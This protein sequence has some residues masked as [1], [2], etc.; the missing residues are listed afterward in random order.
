MAVG[1]LFVV[2]TFASYPLMRMFVQRRTESRVEFYVIVLFLGLLSGIGP[3]GVML[4]E[5]S[6]LFG[7]ERRIAEARQGRSAAK[8]G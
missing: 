7:F 6:R 3:M 5:A 2:A 8:P 4:F 1:I